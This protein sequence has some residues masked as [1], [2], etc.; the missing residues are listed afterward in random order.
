LFFNR[1][2]FASDLSV[3]V[4]NKIN[5]VFRGVD[6]MIMSINS[7][8]C[9]ISGTTIRPGGKRIEDDMFVAFD[10]N[11]KNYRFDNRNSRTL[12]TTEYY[13]EVWNLN[14]QHVNIERS[15]IIEPSVS[16]DS[17]FVDLRALFLFVPVGPHLPNDYQLKIHEKID[18]FK[19]LEYKKM[20]NNIVK[21]KIE[22]PNPLGYSEPLTADFFVNI[23][24]GYA[25]QY[26]E[27]N[28][29]YTMN[30]SWKQINKVWVPVTYVFKSTQ[31]IEVEWKIDWEIVNKEIPSKYF[32]LKEM[33]AD[34]VVPLIPII[35]RELGS[36]VI[37]G[38]IGKGSESI[39][40]QPQRIQYIR[41]FLI[42]A[43]LVLLFIG[44]IKHG[45]DRWKQK[46]EQ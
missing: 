22:F 2:I 39:V 28:C 37:I 30:I 15:L 8:I 4:K 13:Y 41:L 19:G 32:S 10:Y 18:L 23:T 29:G 7:G 14:T 42:I 34:Q 6:D 46:R 25:V 16:A 36:P 44:I 24:N 31:G 1:D 21:V 17:N 5:M 3:D 43:G 35:T 33:V 40:E 26:I 38:K 9:R 20:P 27:Y 11:K 12:S 45:Y